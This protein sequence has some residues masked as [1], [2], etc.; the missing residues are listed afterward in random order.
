MDALLDGVP[1]V[2][3][4][5]ARPE[6][7]EILNLFTPGERPLAGATGWLIESGKLAVR[8]WLIVV[9]TNRLFC[10][11]KTGTA[12]IRKVELPLSVIKTAHTDARLGYHEVHV[13]STS[14]KIVISGMPKDA[15]VAIA[16]AITSAR[17][18]SVAP[19]AAS[20]GTTLT[21]VSTPS[22]Y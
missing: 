13:E 18:A 2:E 3:R 9:T 10:A 4:W 15:A 8:T 22:T 14:G 7:P 1:D 21:S 12:A 17:S 6:V 11:L 19:A 20:T 16:S 5:G